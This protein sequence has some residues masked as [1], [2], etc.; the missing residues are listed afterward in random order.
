MDKMVDVSKKFF[1]IKPSNISNATQNLSTLI[2]SN[3]H[4]EIVKITDIVK[5]YIKHGL[6]Q[7]IGRNGGRGVSAKGIVN[8]LTEPKKCL[9]QI[10][11][12]FKYIGKNATVIVSPEGKII[13]TF[14]MSRGSQLW[15]WGKDR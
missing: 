14:G 3:P 12:S 5:G 6:N 15:N 11:G 1:D 9:E 8:A 10:D 13:T 7:T 2:G 4:T